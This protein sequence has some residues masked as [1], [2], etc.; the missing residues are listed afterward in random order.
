MGN[1]SLKGIA[2]GLL[3]M[4]ILAIPVSFM[5]SY[6]FVA[7]Y[8]DIAPGINLT[9]EVEVQNMT[10]KLI[11]HPLSVAYIILSTIISV[12]VPAYISALVAKKAFI[13]NAMAIGLLSLM[14]FVFIKDILVETPIFSIILVALTLLV[15]YMA[16]LIRCRQVKQNAL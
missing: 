14:S 16:G 2:A 10:F 3:A 1:L 8:N 6:F 4:F 7:I 11:T 15:T 13:L 5:F 9:D 12:G